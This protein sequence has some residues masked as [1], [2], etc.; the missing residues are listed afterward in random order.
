MS[1]MKV[2]SFTVPASLDQLEAL[3]S[4]VDRSL[5]RW[6]GAAGLEQTRYDVM[7]ALQE[8]CV[9]IVAHAYN[10]Q[11]GQLDVEVFAGEAP[12]RLEVLLHDTGDPFDPSA[13]AE[14]TLD[15]PQAGGLGLFLA[16]HLMD[17]V[18]YLPQPDG[19]RWRLV[20]RI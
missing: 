4:R 9:N 17:E 8:I 14:P 15:D 11:P 1:L 12:A 6:Q 5:D 18:V 20:K 2:D 13:V 3:E 7:L 16:R 19:N 10:G